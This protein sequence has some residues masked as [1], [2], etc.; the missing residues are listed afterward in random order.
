[1]TSLTLFA[2]RLF[3]QVLCAVV[4]PAVSVYYFLTYQSVRTVIVIGPATG[5]VGKLPPKEAIVKVHEPFSF[6]SGFLF[7]WNGT[8][9]LQDGDDGVLGI[10]QPDSGRD[11][12]SPELS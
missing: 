2:L 1:L 6:T 3:D 4:Y 8:D 7:T 10:D 5:P 9:S 11:K 12:K